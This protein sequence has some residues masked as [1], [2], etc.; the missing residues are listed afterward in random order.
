MWL[1]LTPDH[2]EETRERQ[3][4]GLGEQ[5]V[6]TVKPLLSWVKFSSCRGD[7]HKSFLPILT[8]MQPSESVLQRAS[9]FLG[10]F[11]SVSADNGG[12]T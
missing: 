6:L 3:V 2:W 8:R 9:S 11:K 1:V 4:W 10:H 5:E 12:L 7:H